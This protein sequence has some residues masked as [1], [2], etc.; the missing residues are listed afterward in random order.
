MYLFITS[1]HSL[2]NI[3]LYVELNELQHSDIICIGRL[4]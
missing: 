1:D 3:P 2:N 4:P